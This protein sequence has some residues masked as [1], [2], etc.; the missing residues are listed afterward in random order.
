M[1]IYLPRRISM[2]LKRARNTASDKA[3][4]LDFRET[5]FQL[6]PISN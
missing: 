6:T 4:A 1:M 3:Q 2:T 5:N